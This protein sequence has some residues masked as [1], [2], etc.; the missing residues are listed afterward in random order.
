MRMAEYAAESEHPVMI[1]YPK[2]LCP[3]EN[4]SHEPLTE[5][6][7]KF[8]YKND[9]EILLIGYGGYLEEIVR[10]GDKLSRKGI[11][12]DIYNMRFLKPVDEKYLVSVLK[13]YKKVFLF[14][15]N[16]EINGI[17]EYLISVIHKNSLKTRFYYRGLQDFFPEH[18]GRDELIA[19]NGLDS[20]SIVSFVA[21]NADK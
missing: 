19:E 15:D 17:G 1:R 21:E 12:N 18:A 8:L 11:R 20:G 5:G 7:G 14:D 9:S 13:N 10:A 16:F 2:S 6:R 3:E 4:S